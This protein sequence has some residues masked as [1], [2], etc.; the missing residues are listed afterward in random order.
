MAIPPC[1]I[2]P[3]DGDNEHQHGGLGMRYEKRRHTLEASLE[4]V[5]RSRP[6]TEGVRH[7]DGLFLDLLKEKEREGS[8]G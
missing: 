1:S 3:E 8:M 4:H 2:E 6:H 5:T 7:F